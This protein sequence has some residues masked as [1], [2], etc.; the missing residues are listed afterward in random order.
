MVSGKIEHIDYCQCYRDFRLLDLFCKSWDC[1]T[2]G[3][4]QTMQKADVK[5]DY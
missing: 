5:L 2:E 1:K 4:R 3:Q